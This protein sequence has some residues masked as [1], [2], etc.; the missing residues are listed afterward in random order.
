[1]TSPGARCARER[2][3]VTCNKQMIAEKGLELL[4]LAKENQG[5]PA[6]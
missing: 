5:V 4:A 2:C 3:F 1:M 6:L